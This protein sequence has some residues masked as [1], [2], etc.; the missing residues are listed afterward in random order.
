MCGFKACVKKKEL[1]PWDFAAYENDLKSVKTAEIKAALKTKYSKKLVTDDRQLPYL[2]ITSHG[3][4]N[5]E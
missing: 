2:F 5:D 1:L 4:Q 3:F